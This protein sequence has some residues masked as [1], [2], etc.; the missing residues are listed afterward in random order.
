MNECL[1]SDL[2]EH[3]DFFYIHN[4]INSDLLQNLMHSLKVHVMFVAFLE[5]TNFNLELA[6]AFKYMKI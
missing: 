1:K 6:K 3:Y 5:N 2:P 4:C